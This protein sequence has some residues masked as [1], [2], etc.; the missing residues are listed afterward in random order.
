MRGSDFETLGAEEI[1]ETEAD[2]RA[3]NA[4]MN[5]FTEGLIAEFE[6]HFLDLECIG[7]RRWTCAP[8]S[9]PVSGLR[10]GGKR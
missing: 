8:A 4:Q 2:G 3:T 9:H 5:D 7:R 1:R 6:S 10:S